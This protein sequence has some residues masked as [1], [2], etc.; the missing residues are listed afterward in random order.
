VVQVRGP[1][2]WQK[3]RR[4]EDRRNRLSHLAGS[5]VSRVGQ[6]VSPV[7]TF[8]TGNYLEMVLHEQCGYFY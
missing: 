5:E 3:P 8:V 6:S 2:P 4:C 7:G 1:D